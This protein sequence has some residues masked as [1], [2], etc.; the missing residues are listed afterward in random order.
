EEIEKSNEEIK[1][2]N[3]RINDLYKQVESNKTTIQQSMEQIKM[4]RN[5]V[6]KLKEEQG[7]GFDN[8]YSQWFP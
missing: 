1:I 2:K 3:A 8:S 4:L 6:E 7:Q 5:E